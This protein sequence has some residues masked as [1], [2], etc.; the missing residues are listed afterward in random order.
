MRI[1]KTLIFHLLRSCRG[2]VL[3]ISKVFALLSLFGCGM[4]LG[5]EIPV[6]FSAKISMVAFFIINTAINWFY[7]ELVFCFQPDHIQI[8][9]F[10]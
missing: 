2:I 4:L 6:P 9:I 7:D 1:L 5:F 10:N 8:A 3:W